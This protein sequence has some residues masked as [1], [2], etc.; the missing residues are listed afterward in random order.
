MYCAW[1]G[2]IWSLLALHERAVEYL[3]TRAA[4]DNSLTA[5]PRPQLQSWLPSVSCL[6]LFYK[7]SVLKLIREAA[8]V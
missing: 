1:I 7:C 6:R 5:R 8:T 4:A 3:Q 2:L